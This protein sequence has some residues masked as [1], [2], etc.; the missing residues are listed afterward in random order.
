MSVAALE[1]ACDLHG[2]DKQRLQEA[3]V[4]L[5]SYHFI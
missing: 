2:L 4:G 1:L 5:S 3:H